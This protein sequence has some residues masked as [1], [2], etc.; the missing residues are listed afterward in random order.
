MGLSLRRMRR[1]KRP[2]VFNTPGPHFALS[3]LLIVIAA[4]VCA[5]RYGKAGLWPAAS[6]SLLFGVIAAIGAF[7]FGAEMLEQMASL[8]QGSSQIGGAVAMSLIAVQL[9]MLGLP[10]RKK[11][12]LAAFGLVIASG[13]VAILMPSLTMPMFLIWLMIAIVAAGLL[14]ARGSWLRMSRAVMTGIFLFNV[15]AIRQSPLL[16]VGLS[17]HLFHTLIAVWLLGLLW[18][19]P[20]R[21]SHMDASN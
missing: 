17:W 9:L 8:H 21:N 1:T 20:L 12:R 11:F 4:L 7:R 3:E 14:P 16:G 5:V 2:L 10:S 13:L 15:V 19:M 6:G 18:V